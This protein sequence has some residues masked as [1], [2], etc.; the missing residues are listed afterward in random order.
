MAALDFVN[1]A[2]PYL[3][4]YFDVRWSALMLE[5]LETDDNAATVAALERAIGLFPY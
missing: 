3:D 2:A 1:Q 5:Q 4:A